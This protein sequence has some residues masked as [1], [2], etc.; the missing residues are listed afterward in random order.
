M[1]RQENRQNEQIIFWFGKF[2]AKDSSKHFMVKRSFELK[3]FTFGSKESIISSTIG[4]MGVSY[5]RFTFILSDGSQYGWDLKYSG[6]KE[7]YH[8]V[9][10]IAKSLGVNT[11]IPIT[12][13]PN[14]QFTGSITVNGE[15]QLLEEA[16]GTQTHIIGKSYGKEWAWAHCNNFDGLK[17]AYLEVSCTAGR[18]TFGFH[19]GENVYF[20]NTPLEIIRTKA[21][22]SP[23]NLE[24]SGENMRYRIKGKIDVSM[25][26][27]IAIEYLGP[28]SERIICYNSEL[29]N[30]VVEVYEKS[31]NKEKKEPILRAESKRRC[32]F[33]TTHFEEIE[34]GPKI[35]KWEEEKIKR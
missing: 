3:N 24:F 10:S 12:A 6:F 29:A 18:C 17:D 4:S 19:D 28:H 35:L 2:S 14:I 23:T 7:P 26:D 33:E 8:H 31:S 5:S 30:C 22:Y 21:N 16:V 27:L 9:P 32:A 11:T 20:F 13:H 34:N 25:K 15:T 1:K